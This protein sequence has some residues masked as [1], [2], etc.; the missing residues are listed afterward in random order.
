MSE[1]TLE[2]L[3]E[4][5]DPFADLPDDVKNLNAE[6]CVGEREEERK[7]E[8]KREGGGREVERRGEG[9]ETGGV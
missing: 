5:E 9:E 6:V 4:G 1:K 2:D 8:K 3:L 7:R